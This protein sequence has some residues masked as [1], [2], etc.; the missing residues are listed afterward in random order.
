M[1]RRG[2]R[3]RQRQA[4]ELPSLSLLYRHMPC[5]HMPCRRLL[6]PHRWLPHRWRL[7]LPGQK[8][9]HGAACCALR[10]PPVVPLL[11]SR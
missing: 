11:P 10:W 8:R 4:L 6:L 7:P 9:A 2:S 5:R 1:E 3:P